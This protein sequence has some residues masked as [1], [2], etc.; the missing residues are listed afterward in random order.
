MFFLEILGM[1]SQCSSFSGGVPT[2]PYTSV[3]KASSCTEREKEGANEIWALHDVIEEIAYRAMAQKVVEMG[4]TEDEITEQQSEEILGAIKVAAHKE[5]YKKDG[6]W[7]SRTKWLN[8]SQF[9]H[10]IS[11]IAV[12]IHDRDTKLTDATYHSLSELLLG[13]DD[14]NT[15]VKTILLTSWFK[16]QEVVDESHMHLDRIKERVSFYQ[17]MDGQLRFCLRDQ[18]IERKAFWDSYFPGIRVGGE[19]SSTF[20]NVTE[21]RHYF[22]NQVDIKEGVITLKTQGGSHYEL[23]FDKLSNL[24]KGEIG[25]ETLFQASTRNNQIRGQIQERLPLLDS[26]ITVGQFLEKYFPEVTR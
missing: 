6:Y 24:L 22:C 25:E 18:L 15:I 21:V 8:Q 4:I 23:S 12:I 19:N 17:H 20:M 13:L 9:G 5:L 2:T 10:L 26:D 7:A 11:K 1:G 3:N 14:H 16:C